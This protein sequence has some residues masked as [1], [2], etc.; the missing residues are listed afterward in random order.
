MPLTRLDDSIEAVVVGR[1]EGRR[2][3]IA[4][5]RVP[6]RVPAEAT[7]LA[8]PHSPT[9]RTSRADRDWCSRCASPSSRSC[10]RR[11]ASTRLRRRWTTSPASGSSKAPSC[12]PG[13]TRSGRS[14]ATSR[15][16]ARSGVAVETVPIV[17]GT[18]QSGGRL[19]SEAFDFFDAKI[20]DGLLEA[21]ALDGIVMLLHGAASAD[22]LDDVEG[23]LLDSVRA[24][25]RT[26]TASRRDARPP[27]QRD[28]AND[29]QRR[30]RDG[31]PHPTARSV[32]DRSR[33][34][35]SRRAAVRRR[36]RSDDGV[37]QAADDDAPGAVPDGAW[38]DEGAVR[39]RAGDG[40]RPASA[41]GLAVPDAVL[42]RRRGGGVVDRR[43]DRR[44]ARRSPTSWPSSSPSWPGRCAT[45]SS[46]PR[47]SRS[48]TRCAAPTR[49]D[50][51]TVLLSDT[52]DSVLG[53]S[54]GDSTVILEAILP[55]GHRR[56]GARADDRQ[57]RR[58]RARRGR[59]RRDGH[60]V[61][62]WPLDTAVH[63]ARGHRRGARRRRRSWS[64]RRICPRGGINMGRCV[65]FEVG[66][67]TL[68]V[69]EFAGVGGHPSGGVPPR[70]RRA[71][72]TIR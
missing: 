72:A 59:C 23:A 3:G 56:P 69:T 62:R 67:V 26:V 6:G 40:E 8:P 50:G 22:G 52:G 65:A 30:H 24:R 1:V 41:D 20:R 15:A 14:A 27:R 25:R 11:A 28:R 58:R 68:L 35:P 34:H 21:G 42:A 29:A 9:S 53:G 60:P 12:S 17:R 70:R 57:R 48:T 38:T 19:T 10:R 4:C 36:D 63:A 5:T 71:R 13:P 2:C 54:G 37:A 18:A 45:S 55:T 49:S 33:P 43:R 47:A 66:P 16:L 46:G 32:R 44:R 7:A 39:P 51:N 31:L 64:T 61:A